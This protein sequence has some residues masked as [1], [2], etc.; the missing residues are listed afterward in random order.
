MPFEQ[1]NAFYFLIGYL[2][3]LINLKVFEVALLHLLTKCIKSNFFFICLFSEQQLGF[4]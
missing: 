3:H 4:S 1:K 2:I